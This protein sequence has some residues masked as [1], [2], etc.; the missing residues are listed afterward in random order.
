MFRAPLA[1]GE[2]LRGVA[3]NG[4]RC[5]KVAA[6]DQ[7]GGGCDLC[8]C[9]NP[10]IT[11][12]RARRIS[13]WHD[14]LCQGLRLGQRRANVPISPQSIFDVGSISK[15][16]TAASILLLE[17]QGKLRLDDDIRKYIP[18]LPEYSAQTGE[19]ITL[20]NI[21]NH[22][23]GLRDYVSL[24]LLAGVHF[25]NATTDNDA[26]GI[27]VR[28]KG[29]NFVPGSDWQYTGS[30]Y[31]LLSLVVK[32]V[33][34]KRLKEFAAEHIFG[35]LGMAHTQY[36]NDHTSLIPNRVL[37]YE[38]TASGDYRLSVSYAEQNGDGM[39]QTSLEDLQKWDE[40]FYSG[41]VGGRDLLHKMEQPGA[42]TIG[43]SL[44]YAKGLS[45]SKYRGLRT[46]CTVVGRG[47]IARFFFAFLSSTSPS[48]VC[49]ITEGGRQG[50]HT[51]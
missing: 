48:R 11:W 42:L 6:A 8:R 51:P 35:P 43:S 31:F 32:R 1:V 12:L 14:Y 33:T 47:A 13:G 17:Q 4:T 46:V 26:L 5:C 18:E 2:P 40:N 19:K 39:V 45:V 20:L 28:Q 38:P 34:G 37:A 29:L 23:S 36:R 15:Q 44:D 22:T 50:V 21:L 3:G 9:G 16:F 25:D 49:V 7:C 41:R 10:R 30:G 24:L 27:L